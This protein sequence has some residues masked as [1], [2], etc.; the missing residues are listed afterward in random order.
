MIIALLLKYIF[1]VIITNIVITVVIIETLPPPLHYQ[2]LSSLIFI[3]ISTTSQF[4]ASV[5]SLQNSYVVTV[6][7][8]DGVINDTETL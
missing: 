7:I 5:N 4:V 1:T 3:P 6:S 2:D 8:T